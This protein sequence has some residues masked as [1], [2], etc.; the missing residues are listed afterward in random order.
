MRRTTH[1]SFRHPGLPYAYLKQHQRQLLLY[2]GQRLKVGQCSP[3]QLSLPGSSA[4]LYKPR[5][6]RDLFLLCKDLGDGG[7]EEK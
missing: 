4:G 5:I 2:T 1:P 3:S 6:I 7:R